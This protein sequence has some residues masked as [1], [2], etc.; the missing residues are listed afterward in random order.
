MEHKA[1]FGKVLLPLSKSISNRLL[2]IRTLMTEECPMAQLSNSDD[3]YIM[4]QALGAQKKHIDVR[5]A[6]TAMR[7]L[8]AFLAQKEG[9]WEITGSERMQQRPI[10]GLVDALCCLGAEIEYMGKEGF[11]P[12]R[13]NGKFLLGGEIEISA[14]VSS[15]YVSALMLIAPYMKNG[16]VIHLQGKVVSDAY[17]NMTLQM[18]QIYGAEVVRQGNRI[19]VA[20]QPYRSVV[21]QV[22]ADW[23]AASY[24]YELLAVVRNGE[25]HLMGLKR[26]SLQGDKKQAELWH[27][28]GVASQFTEKGLLLTSKNIEVAFLEYDFVEMP[29]LIPSFVVACCLLNIPFKFR[30]IE[31]LRIKESDRVSALKNELNKIGYF[32]KVEDNDC[33]SWQGEKS[34]PEI[35]PWIQTYQDHRLAMA[36]AVATLKFPDLQIEN[37]EVV[38]KSFPRFWEEWDHIVNINDQK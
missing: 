8:T 11:P 14:S 16:L 6:G 21:F 7:F 23:S 37:K 36:F 27:K 28:L 9:V 13:I 25:L 1:V 35:N 29:D 33:L 32:L 17:I 2:L 26:D 24:F 38:S 18:M 12:L 20:P 34:T 3:T 10:G 31:T 22:E 5:H 15:Q 4:F 30:G 19:H